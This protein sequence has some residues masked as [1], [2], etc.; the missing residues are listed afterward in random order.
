MI[1][2][3]EACVVTV[4][5]FDLIGASDFMGKVEIPLVNFEDKRRSR[6]W[7]ALTDEGGLVDP[8]KPRGAVDPRVWWKHNP[9]VAALTEMELV[10]DEHSEDGGGGVGVEGA[11]EGMA[12]GEH[13]VVEKVDINRRSRK[14]GSGSVSERKGEGDTRGVRGG[15][16]PCAVEDVAV[17]GTA[18]DEA[19]GA[20]RVRVALL[21]VPLLLAV[22]KAGRSPYLNFGRSSTVYVRVEVTKWA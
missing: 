3:G 12:V 20:H 5:D 15:A 22:R 18:A 8:V 7:Y 13:E 14:R 9:N 19:D 2:G 6:K 1:A 21:E 4:L 17:N 11:G 10:D 16:G